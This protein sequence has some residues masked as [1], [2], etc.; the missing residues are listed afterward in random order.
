[1][2]EIEL[3]DP[4]LRDVGQRSTPR[5]QWRHTRGSQLRLEGLNMSETRND[6]P[7]FA[8]QNNENEWNEWKQITGNSDHLLERSFWW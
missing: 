6:E 4:V 3:L 7:E 8:F 2:G 1:M 5:S